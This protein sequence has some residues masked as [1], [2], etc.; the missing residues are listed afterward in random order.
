MRSIRKF[1]YATLL[2]LTTLNYAPSLA[3]AQ[4]PARGRF[5]LTHDVHWQNALV[6]A[7]EYRFSFDPSGTFRVLNLSNVGRAGTGFML[8]VPEAEETKP[9]DT[10]RLVIES[11]P[12]GS[13]VS[14]MQLAEFG[15]T[16][17]FTVPLH[18]TERQIAKAGT[19]A[20]ASGQ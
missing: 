8:L 10:S 13:Y 18:T 3:S 1:I 11:T 5:T 17:Y 16:L 12:E 2:T 6:P 19:R 4:E 7:G 20:A 14:A 9:T 15:M